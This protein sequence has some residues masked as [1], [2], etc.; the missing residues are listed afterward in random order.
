MLRHLA[1]AATVLVAVT[2]VA[3]PV[4]AA[5]RTNTRFT[6]IKGRD[7]TALAATVCEPSTPGPHPTAV[8]VAAWGGGRTQNI[9]PCETLASRGYVAVSYG[10]RGFGESGGKVEVAGA[11]DITDVSSVIDWT[12]ANT[13]SDPN[14]IGVGGISYGAGIS[15]LASAF[16]PRIRAV[17]SLSG[18]ADLIASLYGNQTRR[19]AVATVLRLSGEQNGHL[20]DETRSMLDKYMRDDDV[21]RVSQWA[22]ERSA[23][24]HLNAINRNRPAT[25]MVSAW[26]ET[27]FPPRQMVDFYRGLTTPKRLELV[28]GEHASAETSGL[29][30]LTNESWTSVYRWFD[31]HLAG[32]DTSISREPSLVLKPRGGTDRPREHYPDWEHVTDADERFSLAGNG[33]MGGRSAGEQTITAGTDTVADGGVP[34][35]TYTFEGLTGEPPAVWLPAVDRRNAAVWTSKPLDGNRAVRGSPHVHLTTKPSTPDGML[36]SYLY[37][38]DASGH[39]KMISYAPYTFRGAR[40]GA[41]L[42]VDTALP[43]TA[44]DVPAGHRLSL[45]VDTKDPLFFLDNN[46]PGAPLGF[47]SGPEASWMTLALHRART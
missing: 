6:E 28:P 7:G 29:L 35:V 45:V 22:R 37:D 3:T 44:Y 43:P 13:A 27:V 46:K 5:D 14:R 39:A 40:P 42:T 23:A 8:L 1:L 15:I 47:T 4:S 11:D 10:T 41:P 9:V 12:L 30:G 32:T 2:T 19:A 16:D 26:N 38:V 17:A 18:W 21:P 20:S 31:A 24:T 25:L 33:T 36:V 34:L